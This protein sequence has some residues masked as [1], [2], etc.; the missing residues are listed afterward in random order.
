MAIE[1]IGIEARTDDT[2]GLNP[3]QWQIALLRETVCP[4]MSII[5]RFVLY[6]NPRWDHMRLAAL[7]CRCQVAQPLAL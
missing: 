2:H 3:N 6:R 7:V 4:R 1:T 5:S